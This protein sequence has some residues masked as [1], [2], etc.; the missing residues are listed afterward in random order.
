MVFCSFLSIRQVGGSV[1]GCFFN[2]AEGEE[3]MRGFNAVL[4][5]FRKRGQGLTGDE[6]EAIRNFM[7][8]EAISP[9]F[10]MRVVREHG[11]ESI[12]V[13]YL[14][15]E[16]DSDK[17]LPYLLRRHK[18]HFY[19][20]RYPTLSLIGEIAPGINAPPEGTTL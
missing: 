13:V 10:V 19:R 2:P 5:G 6:I 7:E 8:S 4:A 12:G 3:F 20:K 11:G 9:A 15:Q 18:G 14:V 17:D 1:V 16:F